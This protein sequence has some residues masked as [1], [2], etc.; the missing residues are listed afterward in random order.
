MPT[1]FVA[2]AVKLSQSESCAPCPQK[3][4]DLGRKRRTRAKR[5]DSARERT[6]AADVTPRR[7]G[8]E[9]RAEEAHRAGRGGGGAG[10]R[11][12]RIPI[13]CMGELFFDVVGALLLCTTT[14][15]KPVFTEPPFLPPLRF[16][17]TPILGPP[18]TPS[19]VSRAR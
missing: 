17:R 9:H 16:P 7:H 4:C 18:V 10:R 6:A 14:F 12:G 3:N 13:R 1:Q 15:C 8:W 19:G 11:G 5:N 2:I